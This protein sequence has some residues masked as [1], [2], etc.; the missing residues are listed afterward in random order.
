MK[1]NKKKK[2][3]GGILDEK[4]LA[5]MG[6]GAGLAGSLVSTFAPP[7][8]IGGGVAS[9]ALSGAAS[10]S[11]LGPAG[12]AA[13]AVVGGVKGFVDAKKAREE[14]AAAK[15]FELEQTRLGGAAASRAGMSF[16][17]G[18][19]IL[20]KHLNV[21]DG[22]SLSAL[23]DDAVEV[24]ATN[25]SETDSVEL[26]QAFVDHNE[27]IDKKNRVFSDEVL[28]PDG[29]SV[30]KHAKRLERMKSDNKRFTDANSHI[31]SKVDKLFDYQEA[32]KPKG[33]KKGLQN[34][35]ELDP[36]VFG[37]D[38]HKEVR[39]P[40]VDASM[41]LT[42]TEDI[43]ENK[44]LAREIASKV[45]FKEALGIEEV[46]PSNY[47][48][49]LT[50]DQM[51]KLNLKKGGKIK[52]TYAF[53]TPDLTKTNKLFNDIKQSPYDEIPNAFGNMQATTPM[54]QP[55]NPFG[56]G[57]DLGITTQGGSNT[58]RFLDIQPGTGDKILD[59]TNAIGTFVPNIVNARL[60]KKLKGPAQPLQQGKVRLDR[61][62]PNAQL[63]EIDRD[64]GLA[65]QAI[66]KS[67]SQ[68]SNIASATGSLLAKKLAAK[69][70]VFGQTNNANT[71]ISNQESLV[72]ADITGKNLGKRDMFNQATNDFANR[73]LQ[74]TSENVA[75][76][77][78][79]LQSMNRERNMMN[80]DRDKFEI[81]ME[82]YGELPDAM[83]SKYKTFGKMG[84]KLPKKLNKKLKY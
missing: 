58:S 37:K 2:A 20:A 59:A 35:G 69:N 40:F 30:S 56:K 57:L 29:K 53:G 16:K 32:V 71:Q 36:I 82:R 11:A 14:E 26:D 45:Q 63:K 52:G 76:A 80:L 66:R 75:N 51:K 61:I 4:Q 79:K 84:G 78:S 22:G 44:A 64:A 41:R 47:Y 72:N 62:D 34:G 21:Q 15:Q 31:E 42:A 55:A 18:G 70:Q 73:K 10:L 6:A 67:T 7:T 54:N 81:M 68:A 48:E 43:L 23:S 19:K 24:K 83:K 60:Q 8:S 46:A 5:G 65:G 39:R 50:S 25:P 49:K 3:S 1:K 12:M 77:S 13:G 38:L 9:G 27:V 28:M 17:H 74:L 33:I